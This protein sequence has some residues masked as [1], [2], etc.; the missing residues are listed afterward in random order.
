[1][2]PVEGQRPKQPSPEMSE[3]LKEIRQTSLW[4]AGLGAAAALA[5]GGTFWANKPR[6]AIALFGVF[7]IAGFVLGLLGGLLGNGGKIDP[8]SREAMLASVTKRRVVLR[9]LA[10]VAYGGAVLVTL[11]VAF[12]TG[13]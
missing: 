1:M 10:L 5:V 11:C 12:A 6:F 7:S 9:N 8:A 13:A 3:R 2:E 4:I